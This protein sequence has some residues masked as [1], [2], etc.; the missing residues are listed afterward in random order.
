MQPHLARGLLLVFLLSLFPSATALLSHAHDEMDHGS[1]YFQDTHDH[2]AGPYI[3]ILA[4]KCDIQG[5]SDAQGN[6]LYL[7]K[8]DNPITRAELVKIL[9]QCSFGI[10]PSVSQNPFSDVS[11]FAWYAPFI[12]KAKT[13]GWIGGYGDGTFRPDRSLNRAEAVK[14]ILLAKFLDSQISTGNVTL[15]DI[16]PY[17]WYARFVLFAVYKDYVQGYRDAFGSLTGFFGP[18]NPITRGEAAKIIVNVYGW[19][20]TADNANKNYNENKNS[21]SGNQNVNSGY[22]NVN[23][24]MNRNTNS[25]AG[26]GPMIG[27]CPVFPTDNPWNQD[28]SNLPVHSNSANFISSM[29]LTTNLHADFGGNGEYGIP[30]IT[31]NSGQPK[32]PINFTAYGDE[33]DPGPYPIPT[34]API[35]GGSNSDGDRHVLAVDTDACMLYELYR[36]FPQSN[37]WNADSA[38]KYDLRSNALRPDYWTSADAAGLPILPGLARYDEVAAGVVQHALRFTVSRTQKGFIHPATHYASS[39]TDANLPPMGLR[40]RLK[41]TYDLSRFTGQSRVILEGL[42]KYGMIVSDNGSNWFI[43]GAS[44]TRWNDD[45]LNQLKTVPGNA[46]EAVDTGPII[47]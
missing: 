37:S 13:L 22:G 36:A 6:L 40:V 29:G 34:N 28:V 19:M 9:V 41:S 17:A 30:Y 10:A 4:G 8:P 33:S 3:D 26:T 15:R 38:A 21:P 1:G 11:S 7:F 16:D 39:S 31:V 43:T 47:K 46:F 35:E 25:T 14:M 27:S 32:L 45:D 24:N 12:Y 44:D 42:K 5:Y 2:W 23:Q 18:G 20:N